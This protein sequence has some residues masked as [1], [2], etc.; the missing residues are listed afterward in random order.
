MI[1]LYIEPIFLALIQGVSEFIPISSTAHLLVLSKLGEFETSSLE[2]DI[3]LHLGSLIAIVLYFR[4]DLLNINKNKKI[5]NLMILGSLPIVFF[6]F[7]LHQTGLIEI[8]RN[9]NL[10][11]WTTLIFAILLYISDRFKFSKTLSKDLTTKKIFF[12][13]LLQS[14]ALIPGTSR[15]GISITAARFLNFDRVDS[16]KISF[17]L[18]IPALTGASVLGLNDIDIK[19]FEINIIYIIAIF[20]SFIFSYITIKYFLI[21][22]QKFSLNVF[23]Y[24][25]IFLSLVLF[26]I[27]YI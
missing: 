27:I 6:G 15:S 8:L 3:C 13:G 25:R 4:K 26:V 21:Y 5:L 7:I 9:I 12:I 19:N 24:Y 17:Y 2:L 11:A 14:L 16:S 23:I 20:C 1:F 10:I 22:V 18:S